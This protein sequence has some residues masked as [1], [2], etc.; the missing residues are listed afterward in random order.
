MCYTLPIH[1]IS[2]SISHPASDAGEWIIQKMQ[3][4]KMF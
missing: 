3:D 1:H 2:K 4:P